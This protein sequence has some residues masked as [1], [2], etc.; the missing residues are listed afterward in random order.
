MKLSDAIRKLIGRQTQ[1]KSMYVP[2]AAWLRGAELEADSGVALVNA[3][4]QSS[5]VYAAV[6]AKAAKLAQVPFKL[7]SAGRQEG[8]RNVILRQL[9]KRL[10]QLDGRT[11]DRINA[12]S[13]DRLE[14]LEE[15][16]L[17]FG[18]RADLEAWLESRA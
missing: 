4:Q 3:Y 14:E 1:A 12:L 2:S 9:R 7:S 17:D 8:E 18:D 5:W 16:L 15:A 10:G 6:G 11:E 13:A